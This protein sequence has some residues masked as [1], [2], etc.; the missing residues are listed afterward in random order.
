MA[1]TLR[2]TTVVSRQ[3]DLLQA[4]VG[5]SVVL[6]SVELASYYELDAIA[7]AVWQ[8][9]E[10]PTAIDALCAGLVG[11]FDVMPEQCEADVMAFLAELEAQHLLCI[12][13]Q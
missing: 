2:G 8:R 5:S 7:A 12:R 3:P 9:L 6:L 13:D 10:H 11:D 4:N 1:T